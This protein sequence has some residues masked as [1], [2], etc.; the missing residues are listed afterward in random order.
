MDLRCSAFRTRLNMGSCSREAQG[1][2]VQIHSAQVPEHLLPF[3]ACSKVM[4]QQAI[5]LSVE[6][7]LKGLRLKRLVSGSEEFVK[8]S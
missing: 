4:T 7:L 8:S 6:A 2:S 5:H 1:I 3:G